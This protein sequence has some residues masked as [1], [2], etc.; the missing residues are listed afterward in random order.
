MREIDSEDNEQV[1][2]P[3]QRLESLVQ[4]C[5]CSQECIG[6]ANIES[7]KRW[8]LYHDKLSRKEKRIMISY[9]LSS[10]LSSNS[11]GVDE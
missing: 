7:W 6:K 8:L 11:T 10:Q 9:L 1:E 4:A 3:E 2:I 5:S